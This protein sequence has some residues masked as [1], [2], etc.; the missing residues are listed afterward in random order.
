MLAG[1]GLLRWLVQAAAT[2][3][4]T[5]TAG[6]GTCVGVN[7]DITER[8]QGE[9]RLRYLAQASKLLTAS[10]D[11]E[12]TLQQ[13]AET[14]VPFLADWCVLDVPDDAGVLRQVALSHADPAKRVTGSRRCAAAIRPTRGRKARPRSSPRA[15]ALLFPEIPDELLKAER[16]RRGAPAA[17]PRGRHEVGA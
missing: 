16:P 5:P 8:K 13:T 11:V 7:Y 3:C 15:S 1:L 4:M 14:M 6:R 17:H 9:E 12:T 2:F 10:L